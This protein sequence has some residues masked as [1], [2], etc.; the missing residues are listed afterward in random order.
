M[1]FNPHL[2]QQNAVGRSLFSFIVPSVFVVFDPL[3]LCTTVQV[4]LGQAHTRAHT[5]W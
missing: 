2:L 1:F 3:F 4:H 5:Q